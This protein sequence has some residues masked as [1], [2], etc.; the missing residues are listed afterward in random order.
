MEALTNQTVKDKVKSRK[1]L[2]FMG[3]VAIA[4]VAMFTGFVEF[5]M[6]AEYTKWMFGFYVA[7]NA[8]VHGSRAFALK[9]GNGNGKK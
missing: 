6:W 9:N 4:T 1:F 2:I 3:L 8:F 5:T 7:G